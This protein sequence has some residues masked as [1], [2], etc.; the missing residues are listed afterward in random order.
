MQHKPTL[1]LAAL[2]ASI[3]LIPP[4][5][6]AAWQ[7]VNTTSG[8]QTEVD[9]SSAVRKDGVVTG[10]VQHSYTRKTTT[11]TGAYFVYRSMKEQIRLDCAGQTV[12]V[13]EGKGIVGNRA[14]SAPRAYAK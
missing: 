11:Q 5:W 8:V 3:A 6:S 10:W 2:V 7:V 13:Q 12:T 4:A 14:Y 9:L 1:A